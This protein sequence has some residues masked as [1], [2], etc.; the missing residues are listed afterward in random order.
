M[1][2]IDLAKVKILFSSND[3]ILLFYQLFLILLVETTTVGMLVHKS[4]CIS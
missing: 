4:E 3:L 2:T 1:S